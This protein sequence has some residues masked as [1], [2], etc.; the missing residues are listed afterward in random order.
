MKRFKID[1][2]VRKE[3][4]ARFVSKHIGTRKIILGKPPAGKTF[5]SCGV[6]KLF[7]DLGFGQFITELQHV[8]YPELVR[9]LYA[10]Y[11]VE[12]DICISFVGRI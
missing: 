9:E 2:Q 6:V 8:C 11:H 12:H 1:D 4:R 7:P 10:N 5:Y 3:F